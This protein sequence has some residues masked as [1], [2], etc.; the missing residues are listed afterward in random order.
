MDDADFRM[1]IENLPHMAWASYP[2]GVSQYCNRTM[3]EYFGWAQAEVEGIDWSQIVHPDDRQRSV[4]AWNRAV[5]TMTDYRVDYRL[6]RA[7]DGAYRWHEGRATPVCDASGAVVRWVGTCTDIEE[8]KRLEE[9]LLASEERFRS[10]MDLSPDIISIILEDGTLAYNSPAALAIHGYTQEEMIGRNTFDLIHPDDQPQCSAYMDSLVNKYPGPDSV[11]YRYRNQDG[12]YVWM[13]ATAVN[14]YDNPRIRGLIVI[15]RDISKRKELDQAL[16]ASRETLHMVLNSIP[17]SVFWKDLAGRYLGCNCNFAAAAGFKS[18]LQVVGLTDYD[19]PWPRDLADAYRADDCEVM[20]LNLP[21]YGIKERSQTKDSRKLWVETSK[22]PLRDESGQPF[23]VLGISQ[24]ITEIV[25][26]NEELARAKEAAETAN[27][28][29]SAFLANMSH[30][31]RTPITGIMGMAELLEDTDLNAVQRAYLTTILRSSENL[32]DLVNDILDLSRIESGMAKMARKNFSLRELVSD[33]IISQKGL[34]Q[35]KGLAVGCEIS[36]AIPDRFYGDA[37]KLKQIL[38]NLVNNAVK[39]TGSGEVT[40]AVVDRAISD[41]R[42]DLEFTVSD[43]GIGI[44]PDL[45]EKIFEP[46]QQGDAS[47][48][49]Q[50]GGT[51]LGLAICDRLV[52]LLEGTIQVESREGSG[53]LFR[54]R[55]PLTLAEAAAPEVPGRQPPRPALQGQRILLVEDSEASRL[56]FIEVLNKHGYRADVATNGVEALAKWEQGSYDLI[57][58]DIQMPVMGGLEVVNTIREAERQQGGHVPIVAITAHAME[59]DRNI[60]LLQGFDG[61]LSKP[62]RIGDLLDEITRCTRP[63]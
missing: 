30:E 43:T 8:R 27:Q 11:Q 38:L 7:T 20:T 18:P 35:R 32:L 13:E 51:G 17:Q 12:S 53:S 50:Y 59:D 16:L 45:L 19:M 48:S 52:G 63:G 40:V 29:K 26:I 44:R 33:V 10:L 2:D 1:L 62:T 39:F 31:I 55:I 3:R 34:S 46:F 60:F 6:R 41:R 28:A 25:E 15:S 21:K 57:L 56:F 36:A 47:I 22:I 24:D 5:A 42:A 37:L 49:R 54:V 14:Q 58:L 61:Y 23:G 9:T 4:E